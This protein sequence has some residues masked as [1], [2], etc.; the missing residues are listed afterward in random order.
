MENHQTP[1]SQAKAQT[2]IGSILCLSIA[3][4]LLLFIAMSCSSGK[5]ALQQGDYDDAVYKAI[6][7]LQSNDNSKKASATLK[8][9]YNYSLKLH[10]DNISALNSSV[11]PF[12]WDQIV[13]EYEILD[14]QYQGI[15]RCP[16]CQKHIINP[17]SVNSRLQEA[18]QNAAEARYAM[19]TEAMQQKQRREKAIE[20]HEHFYAASNY[21]PR[22]KDTEELMQ[23]ALYHAVLRVVIEPIP[24]PTRNLQLKHEFFYNK[25]METIQRNNGN[26]YVQYYTPEESNAQNLEWIDHVINMEFERFSLGNLVSNTYVEEISRD[27][28]VVAQKD[29]ED[30]YG[31]V[32]AKLAINEKSLLGS[33]L[34]DFQVKD[35]Q[36]R[37]VLTQEKFPSEYQWTVRWATYNGDERALS[38]EQKELVNVVNFDVPGPQYMFEEFA[39]PL[40]DQVVSKVHN[41]YRNF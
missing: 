20:A 21:I 15:Q 33:G 29:G 1:Q 24:S 12:K 7:R 9:A 19:G 14:A 6:N 11:D 10:L 3:S 36:S 41:Y 40:F 26:P 28:V 23:E 31:T 38:A 35:I 22:F 17:L 18:K 16:A 27:S 13:N 30:V 37:R 2:T 4:T 34:L 32:R 8:D 25:I 39:A 5:K